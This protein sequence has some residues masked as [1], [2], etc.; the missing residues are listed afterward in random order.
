LSKAL[1]AGDHGVPGGENMMRFP[2]GEVR[3]YTIRESAR[4]QTFPDDYRFYGSWTESM[5]QLGNA[6][7]VAL[8]QAVAQSIADHLQPHGKRRN[9]QSSR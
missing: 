3:Y 8:A 4:I 7:P 1:K 2:D 6:V 9:L 5:R